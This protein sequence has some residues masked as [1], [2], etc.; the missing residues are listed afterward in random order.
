MFEVW[1]HGILIEAL[2]AGKWVLIYSI[3]APRAVHFGAPPRWVI[4]CGGATTWGERFGCE[5]RVEIGRIGI[6][7]MC[8][9]LAKR[10]CFFF[11]FFGRVARVCTV[12]IS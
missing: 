12:P 2:G 10:L 3:G 1:R 7:L 11:F 5:A 9:W 6:L 4:H 8:F